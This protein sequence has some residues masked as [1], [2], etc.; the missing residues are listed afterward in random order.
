MKPNM[1]IH[2]RP[3]F[4]KIEG[5]KTAEDCLVLSY[6][7]AFAES[8]GFKEF[9]KTDKEIINELGVS[10]STLNRSKARLKNIYCLNVSY[11]G[12]PRKTFYHFVEKPKTNHL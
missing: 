7:Y 2:F 5:V 10:P 9:C 4:R 6:L 8:I 11:K 12:L 1:V 3:E